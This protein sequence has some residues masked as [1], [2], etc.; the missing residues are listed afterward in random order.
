MKPYLHGG[1]AFMWNLDGSVG[2]GGQNNNQS[3]ICYLQW[4]YT[5][6]AQSS[7]VDPDRKVLYKRVSITG[8]CS[9]RDDDPLVQA[10]MAQQ[11]VLNH[12]VI[13]GKASALPGTSGDVRLGDHKAY[14]IIRLGGR[15]AYLYPQSW[16]RLDQMPG[17]PPSVAAAVLAACNFPLTPG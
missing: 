10:I 4:Y 1:A 8:S 13:D 14:F 15:L 7:L 12:P 5:L 11:R 2:K 6:A 3:D 17:C 16:P 9:G